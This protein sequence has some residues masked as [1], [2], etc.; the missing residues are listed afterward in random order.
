MC[1]VGGV[2]VFIVLVGWWLMI[3]F[4]MFV[5]DFWMMKMW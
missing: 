5:I 4:N 1:V 3:G 2:L